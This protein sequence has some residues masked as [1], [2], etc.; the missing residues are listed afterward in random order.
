M[1]KLSIEI[2]NGFEVSI[3]KYQFRIKVREGCRKDRIKNKKREKNVG[4]R[5]EKRYGEKQK[6]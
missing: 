3:Y 1:L 6:H 4:K 5:L 2:Y